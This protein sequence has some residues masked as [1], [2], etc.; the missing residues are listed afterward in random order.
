[1]PR[2]PRRRLAAAERDAARSSN[3][4]LA[5]VDRRSSAETMFFAGLIGTYLVFRLVG[6]GV[7]AARPAAAAAR[8]HR[9]QHARAA[10]ERRPDDAARCARARRDDAARPA[11]GLPLDRASLGAL[12]LAVQGIEW[13][14]PRRPRADARRAACTAATF[15][16]LIGCHAAARRSARCSGSAVVGCVP[17]RGALRRPAAHR[18]ARDVRHLLVLRLRA[19]GRALPAGVPRTDAM[20][21]RPCIACVAAGSPLRRCAGAAQRAR[22]GLRHVRHARSR[23]DDPARRAPSAASILFLMSMPYT[24]VRLAAGWLFLRIVPPR[25]GRAG[26]A[27][28]CRVLARCRA[29]RRHRRRAEREHSSRCRARIVRRAGRVA[30][31]PGELGQARHVDLPRRRRHVVRRRCSPPTARCATA[32]PTWPH[33]STILGIPLTAFMTFLLICSSVTMVKALAGDPAGQPGEARARSSS[34]PSSAAS[35]S[36]ACRPTSGRT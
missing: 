23:T 2:R 31:H 5:I 7:A 32:I 27:S 11:R 34:S 24:V 12:F 18:R 13:V 14:A 33:P 26:A 15:Y 4:R 3:T 25:A 20:R 10:R 17:A 29:R 8:R 22:A 28:S 36:S 16:V 19:V 21:S 35:S 30:A 6:A 9:A 1:M